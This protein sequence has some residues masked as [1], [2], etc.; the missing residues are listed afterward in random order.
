[1]SRSWSSWLARSSPCLSCTAGRASQLDLLCTTLTTGSTATSQST[2]ATSSP[3]R[4]TRSPCTTP[5]T[6]WTAR[7]LPTGSWLQFAGLASPRR[8][9][10]SA[11]G[12]AKPGCSL[13]IGSP[14]S[15]QSPSPISFHV[16]WNTK[17]RTLSSGVPCDLEPR[18]SFLWTYLASTWWT[19]A[20][21]A[22]LA[23][24]A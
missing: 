22:S 24:E 5:P 21:M 23:P 10:P 6:C 11:R 15:P 13:L 1:M 17:C 2:G 20:L 18:R 9:W 14:S 16:L 8:P 12:V 7:L 3:P 19:S 4:T